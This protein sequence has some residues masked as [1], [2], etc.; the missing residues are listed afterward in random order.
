MEEPFTKVVSHIFNNWTALR[1]A[2][3]HSMGGPNSR[4]SAME[5][6]NYMVQYCLY[7]P[8]VE[9]EGIQDALEDILDEEFETVCE[10]DSPKE[11][12]HLLYKFLTLLRQGK[13]EECDQEFQKLPS[14]NSDWL[15]HQ[16]ALANTARQDEESSDDSEEEEETNQ[17]KQENAPMEDDG[18]T[19]VSHRKKR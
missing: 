4:Q 5:F 19:Q 15:N 16:I 11:I 9:V 14:I 7:E 17:P 3:E 13:Y 1:L 12:A 10:D 8:N 2:V 6:L 18:W